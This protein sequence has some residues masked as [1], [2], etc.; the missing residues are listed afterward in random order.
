ME[1]WRGI[2]DT[3]WEK[4]QD[5]LAA[6]GLTDGLPVVPPTP[7]RV[8]AMLRAN[9]C[10]A[11]TVVCDLAPMLRPARWLDIAINAVMAGCQP[12]CLPVVGAALEAMAAEEFNLIGVSTTTGSAAPLVIVNGPVAARL[13]MNSAANALGPGNRANATMGRA[14][15]LCLRNIG[16]ATP[17]EMDMATLGQP[18]KYT[19]CFAENEAQ[20]PWPP[21]HVERGHAPGDSVVTVVGVS[22][23]VE[24]VDSASSRSGDLAQTFAQ[25]LLIAGTV[26]GAGLI[27]GGEPL[28]I[29][30]PELA[31]TCASDGCSKQR[32]KT[33]I[34]ERAV[35]PF[36]CLSP[37]VQEHLTG[38]TGGAGPLRIA[39]KADDILIVVAGG[40]GVKAAY[41]PNWGGGSRAVSRRVRTA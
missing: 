23:T 3:G 24:V 7:A 37:A 5:E 35:M 15:S 11:D 22:G 39:Q 13:G 12:E 18:A 29:L 32:L 33:A 25:S 6:L 36:D 41:A 38:R 14:I 40:V 31:D 19:C 4:A 10:E 21:L 20:S 8:E 1:I 34:F 2:P 9:G 26:G 17:G 27:G 16:G 30:P 28:I